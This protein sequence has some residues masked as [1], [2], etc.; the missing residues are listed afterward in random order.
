MFDLMLIAG[1]LCV[2]LSAF[3]IIEHLHS[4]LVL[5]KAG[6]DGTRIAPGTSL[7]EAQ[8]KWREES[9]EAAIQAYL[10]QRRLGNTQKAGELGAR[11]VDEIIVTEHPDPPSDI[12]C[13]Q[14]ITQLKVLCAFAVNRVL[15]EHA[16]GAIVGQSTLSA[17]Y[18]AVQDRD[19]DF[20]EAI[21]ESG[22]FS[23]YMYL[24]RSEAAEPMAFATAFAEACGNKGSE[25]CVEAGLAAYTTAYNQAVF[26]IKQADFK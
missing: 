15:E 21:S 13:D 24:F 26:L 6:E 23:F 16:P 12:S 22:S 14:F 2:M 11:M 5:V 18:D 17:F 8:A 10:R 19:P 1:V 3:A 4:S 7:S 20:Y 9:E 25:H